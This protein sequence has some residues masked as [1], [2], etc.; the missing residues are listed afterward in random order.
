VSEIQVPDII[1]AQSAVPGYACVGILTL[2]NDD[3]PRTVEALMG[4]NPESLLQGR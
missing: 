2:K 3:D 4:A 1:P